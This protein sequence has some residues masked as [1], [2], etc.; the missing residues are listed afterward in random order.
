VTSNRSSG[1]VEW[2]GAF[3]QAGGGRSRASAN[4]SSRVS[5]T[6]P[7]RAARPGLTA[8]AAQISDRER[9]VVATLR[10][11]RIATA[12]QLE[13][14]HFADVGARERRRVLA[15]LVERRY[16]ARLARRIGGVRAGSAG[17]TFALGTL[18]QRLTDGTGPARGYRIERPWTPGLAFLDHALAVTDVV[19]QLVEAERRGRLRV[20]AYH[21]EPG[22][23][24]RF[25]GLHGAPETLKP[26][27]WLHV[28]IDGC[29]DFW[30]VEVDRGTESPRALARKCEQYRRYWT[31]GQ[32]QH[33]TGVMPRVLFTV[34]D[35]ARHGVVVD[36][37]SRQ[38]AE[39]WPLF[40]VCL[41]TDL[42][43]RIAQGANA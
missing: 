36:T 12:V 6:R 14:L 18:G 42:V 35:A 22:A 17:A 39:S 25:L 24:R 9:A 19:V 32:E 21:A 15:R 26:D 29:D 43:E 2:E 13:R 38:S 1:R 23:W 30:F 11:L 7:S 5:R 31:S 40:A 34:P 41:A 4:D 33:R 27:L 3:S 28:R 37:F 10:Q 20:A 16:L 8:G